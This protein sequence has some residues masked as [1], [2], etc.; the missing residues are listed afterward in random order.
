MLLLER[1]VAELEKESEASGE[2]HARLRQE[3]LQLV[4][5]AN[6]LEEQLKEQEL[7][8]DEQ[9]QQET[10]RHKEALI[11]LERERGLELENL[12]ARW[13]NEKRISLV[14]AGKNKIYLFTVQQIDSYPVYDLHM[15][16]GLLNTV[17]SLCILCW[18]V[19]NA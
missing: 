6:A 18:W 1:R 16:P 8:A 15:L 17:W 12:Q 3:N 5:R 2:Q 10:R 4:H 7:Q 19:K 14:A 9:L 11:K 13:A